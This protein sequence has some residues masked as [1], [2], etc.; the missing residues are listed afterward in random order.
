MKQ[1]VYV[2]FDKKTGILKGTFLT[3]EGARQEKDQNL[4]KSCDILE[5]EVEDASKV[6]F[7]YLISSEGEDRDHKL[8]FVGH[9]TVD[10]KNALLNRLQ[11][12]INDILTY[13]SLKVNENSFSYQGK[14][15]DNKSFI[16]QRQF[17][18]N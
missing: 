3:K 13:D 6:I 2:L 15:L 1:K 16:I 10:A 8:E 17:C 14:D 5:V 9:H 12:N 18:I 4:F 7:M 11:E